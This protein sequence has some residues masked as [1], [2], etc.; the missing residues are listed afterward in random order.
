MPHPPFTAPMKAVAGSMPTGDD[1]AF[2]LKWDG[3]RLHA[4]I[5][6]GSVELRSGSGRD[7]T[8]SFPELL[9]LGESLGLDAVLDGELVVFDG[10]RPSFSRLQKRMH[11]LAPSSTLTETQPVVFLIFDVLRL[12]GHDTLTLPYRDR[13][14]LLANLIE[15]APHWQVP[16]HVENS[17]EGLLALAKSRDLEGVVAKRLTGSYQP[18]SRS[19]AWV[20]VKLRRRQE[21]VIGG[22]LPGS[23][24]LQG[25]LG[26]LLVGVYDESGLVYAGA[27]GSG[28]TDAERRRLLDEFQ[29]SSECPFAGIPDLKK[30]ATWVEPQLVVEVAYA[31]WA[32]GHHLRHPSYEGARPDKSPSTVFRDVL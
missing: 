21:F 15:A 4:S 20:K 27:V 28:L 12:E 31:E 9:G 32:V 18:G 6:D 17:G 3:M 19:S 29:T 24:G 25:S 13:R 22:W 2:E 10:E 16:S 23:G 1:W 7:V 5:A 8:S 26:S 30:S 11:N 14:G